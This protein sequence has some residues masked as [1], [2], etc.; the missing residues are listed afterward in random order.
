MYYNTLCKALYTHYAHF[1]GFQSP[2]LAAIILPF[3][4]EYT[5]CSFVSIRVLYV[6]E[7]GVFKMSQKTKCSC[8]FVAIQLCTDLNSFYKCKNII[9][10]T[11]V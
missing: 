9:M 6:Q 11:Y 7:E 10:H 8:T 4:N 1:A 3:I 5:Y 2:Q